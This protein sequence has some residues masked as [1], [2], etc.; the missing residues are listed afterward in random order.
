MRF[1]CKGSWVQ[2]PVLPMCLA[3]AQVFV[4][5]QDVS[6]WFVGFYKNNSKWLVY[7]YNNE[8]VCVL[9]QWFLNLLLNQVLATKQTVKEWFKRRFKNQT[10]DWLLVTILIRMASS[11]QLW[12]YLLDWFSHRESLTSELWGLMDTRIHLL[13]EPLTST[14][15]GNVQMCMIYNAD[16]WLSPICG[17]S[18][19]CHR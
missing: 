6:W 16:R 14:S 1:I 5:F 17:P 11:I 19:T 3:Y 2:S 10:F 18:D 9:S 13:Q 15:V 12:T 7:P 8:Q 4:W